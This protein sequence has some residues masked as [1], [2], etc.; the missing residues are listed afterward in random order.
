MAVMGKVGSLYPGKGTMSRLFSLTSEQLEVI[1]PNFSLLHGM[2]HVDGLRVIS[3]VIS[4]PLLPGCLLQMG[5][6]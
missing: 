1:R 6:S 2:A 3:G 5:D 4:V